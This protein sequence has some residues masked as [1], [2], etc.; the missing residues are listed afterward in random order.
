M[1]RFER[2][3]SR[4]LVRR[5]SNE[6]DLAGVKTSVEMLLRAA[7]IGSILILIGVSYTLFIFKIG[8]LLD[9]VFGLL[10]ATLYMVVI[11]VLLE[12]KIDG[13]KTKLEEMLPDFLQITAANLRSGV[14]LDRAMLLAAKPEFTYLSDDVK[15][16]N[17]RV[18]GGESFETA[19]KTFASRYRSYQLS[20]AVKMIL[21]GLRYGGAVADLLL[22]IS[23]DMR[24]QQLM[25]K[26]IAGQMFMYSIFIVFAGLIAAPV[27][28]GLTSQMIVTTDTVW[29]GI[30]AQNPGGL[31]TEGI[32]FLKPS[33]PQITPS[34][35]HD[36]SIAAIVVITAFA[37]LIV[38]AISNGS[39]MRGIRYLPVFVILGV[40][41]FLVMVTLVSGIFSSIGGI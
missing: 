28:Y 31:P 15:E 41:I 38:S 13:R 17:R 24:S 19:L 23:K 12:Y 6:I 10:G 40:V 11:Y 27:L 26:E 29:K 1:V 30:L 22:Q 18:F 25:Q 9:M 4:G 7:I 5:L 32:S 37:S 16:M 2:L 8:V 3:V 20:H 33:P 39:A 14:A 35:Y 21:E 36:F 34:E